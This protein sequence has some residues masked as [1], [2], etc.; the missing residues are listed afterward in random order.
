MIDIKPCPCCGNTNL[1]IFGESDFN[2]LQR[3]HGKSCIAIRC[4][5]CHLE[6]FDH[7]YSEMDYNKRLEMLL[8]KWNRRV[9]NEKR[10]D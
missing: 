9:E 10:F 5:E 6:M 8:T 3:K 2:L 7:T 1:D 4:W